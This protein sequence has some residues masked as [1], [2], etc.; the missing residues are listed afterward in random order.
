MSGSIASPSVTCAVTAPLLPDGSSGEPDASRSRSV[1]RSSA[2]AGTGP[3][4]RMRARAGGFLTWE[5]GISNTPFAMVSRRPDGR[6]TTPRPR[7][8]T[9]LRP[10]T[11]VITSASRMAGSVS[12]G[13]TT[14][15]LVTISTDNPSSGTGGPP[16]L[17][18]DIGALVATSTRSTDPASRCSSVQLR[19]GVLMKTGH[20][21]LNA[22]AVMLR[23][24]APITRRG[25]EVEKST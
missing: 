1:A 21:C 25:S 5:S 8:I 10:D 9:T 24:A 19:T 12:T 11:R 18:T 22:A 13:L 3:S 20:I 23:P 2:A 14:V 15:P 7:L 6:S 16:A 4:M 17:N